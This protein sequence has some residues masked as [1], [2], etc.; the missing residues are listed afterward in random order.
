MSHDLHH[1]I[2]TFDTSTDYGPSEASPGD[3]F[4]QPHITQF[5]PREDYLLM[6]NVGRIAAAEFYYYPTWIRHSVNWSLEGLQTSCLDVVSCHDVEY[7]TDED[8]MDVIQVLFERVIRY[9]GISGYP[10]HK[11]I[12]VASLSPA[13]V[14]YRTVQCWAQLRLKCEPGEV[15]LRVYMLLELIVS[16]N[17]SSLGVDMLSSNSVPFGG[18]S[19]WHPT[20]KGL[21]HAMRVDLALL[22]IRFSVSKAMTAQ[23]RTPGTSNEQNVC[24]SIYSG[25]PAKHMDAI[26]AMLREKEEEKRKSNRVKM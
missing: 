12:S 8:A 5:F 4:A 1:G 26:K 10:I 22:A 20:T 7:V 11:L 2:R 21:R 16:F 19:D 9:V 3:A 15:A 23:G 18:L 25:A 6:T 24:S 13:K 17:S 14:G